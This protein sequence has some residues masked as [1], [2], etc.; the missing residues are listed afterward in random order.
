MR[1]TRLSFH[2]FLLTC[3]ALAVSAC[4]NVGLFDFGGTSWQEEAL[5]HD[6][7][8]IVVDR[9]VTRGGPR[10]IGQRGSYTKE[11]LSFTHPTTGKSISWQDKATEDLRNSSFLPMAIDIYKGVVY[12]V[13]S[14]MGCLSYNKRGRPNPP[15]VVFRH[16]GENWERVP[17]QE[18][19]LETNRPNL[20][21]SSPDTEV[22]RLDKRFVDAETIRKINSEFR[23]PWNKAILREDLSKERLEQMCEERILYKGYW[24]LPNAPFAR[25]IIDQRIKQGS[26][27]Q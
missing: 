10:E 8:R 9:S 14:P 13:A 2:E 23:Q 25:T 11:T 18:L 16:S 3:M 22:E 5:L 7:T 12:L 15:Y 20:I 1:N 26:M 19:P 4:S 21:S 24:I 6:G 17:F 27:E